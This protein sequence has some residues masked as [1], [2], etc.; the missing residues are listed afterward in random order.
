MM[1]PR[2]SGDEVLDR[3]AA[4]LPAHPP[5][6][7]MTAAGR[8]RDRALAHRNRYYLPKPFDPT[9]LLATVETALEEATGDA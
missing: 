6:V 9:L 1:L 5:V 2:V 7:V 4:G 3:L 8:A